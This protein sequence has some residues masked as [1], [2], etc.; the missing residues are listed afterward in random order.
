M[1][2]SANVLK[3]VEISHT[4]LDQSEIFQGVLKQFEKTALKSFVKVPA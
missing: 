2:V 1:K 4:V 3:A